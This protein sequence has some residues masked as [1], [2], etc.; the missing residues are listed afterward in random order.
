MK[1]IA[2]FLLA[3][4]LFL[5]GCTSTVVLTVHNKT[6]GTI[7]VWV[8]RPPAGII[9]MGVVVPG[10][11]A[12]RQFVVERGTRVAVYANHEERFA[13]TVTGDDPDPLA[14]VVTVK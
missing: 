12:Y 14:L 8:D 4:C 10:E 5:G 11:P 6:D 13:H 9:D 2:A 7:S 1:R 3:L